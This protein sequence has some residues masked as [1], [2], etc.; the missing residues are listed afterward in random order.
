MTPP[1][2]DNAL[3]VLAELNG[4]TRETMAKVWPAA[5]NPVMHEWLEALGAAKAAGRPYRDGDHLY[6]MNELGAA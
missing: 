5:S 2:S 3:D 6:T 4:C 1:L